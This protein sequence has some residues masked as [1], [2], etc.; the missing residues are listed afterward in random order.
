MGKR[1]DMGNPYT[2]RLLRRIDFC[3]YFIQGKKPYFSKESGR[4][5][6]GR[7]E[8]PTCFPDSAYWWAVNM[9]YKYPWTRRI[10][11]I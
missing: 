9:Q 1:I 6:S 10:L 2:C 8:L 5:L 4:L 3:I 7:W 11:S